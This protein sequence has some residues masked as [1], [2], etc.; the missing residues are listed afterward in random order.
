MIEIQSFTFNGFQEN[1]Y[2]LFDQTKECIIID[3]GCYEKKEQNLL[4]DFIEKNNLK[5]VKLI[6]T[7]CHI[8]HVLGNKFVAEKWSLDLYIH[9]KDL[10]TLKNVNEYCKVYGFHNYEESPEPS[11]FLNHKEKI[12]FGESSLDIYFTPGHAPGHIILHNKSQKFVI[13][14]DVLF[15][16]SIGRTDLPGGDYNTLIESIKENLFIMDDQTVVYCGHGQP[17]KIGFEKINNPFLK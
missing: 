15:Y 10:P 3:P 13:G 12:T 8:D 11:F 7:H 6:N 14:G 4:C 17:T 9:K 2:V 16:M 1:T 5:P